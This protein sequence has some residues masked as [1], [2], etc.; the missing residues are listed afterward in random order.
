[1]RRPIRSFCQQFLHGCLQSSCR[2][3]HR[4]CRRRIAT[5]LQ[6]VQ[7]GFGGW[8]EDD[9]KREATIGL[10]PAPCDQRGRQPTALGG[11]CIHAVSSRIARVSE[12]E[13]SCAGL[14][15]I[16]GRGGSGGAYDQGHFENLPERGKGAEE[17]FTV[18]WRQHV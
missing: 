9:S 18:H 15:S 3:P 10:G 4:L 17:P 14:R 5:G 6:K 8:K 1:L 2:V 12:R 11:E 7:F 16:L 13:V